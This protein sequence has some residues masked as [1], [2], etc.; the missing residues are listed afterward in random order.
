M[1][2]SKPKKPAVVDDVV[3]LA[4]LTKRAN[5]CGIW[6]LASLTGLEYEDILVEVSRRYKDAGS[7][8]LYMGQIQRVAG[9]LGVPLRLK[10]KFDLHESTGILGMTFLETGQGHAAVLKE[11]QLIDNDRTVWSVDSYVDVKHVSVDGLLVL[12][13]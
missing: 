10:R 4:P 2:K 12:S 6:A 7:K 1:P 8:G 13:C 11:G 3:H 5:D 9:A